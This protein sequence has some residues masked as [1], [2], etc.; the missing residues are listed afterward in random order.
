MKSDKKLVLRS[1]SDKVYKKIIKT[2]NKVEMMNYCQNQ[3]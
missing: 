1:N 2:S 3:A